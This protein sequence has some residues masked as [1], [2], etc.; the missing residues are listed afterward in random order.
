VATEVSQQRTDEVREAMDQVLDAE[1]EAQAEID[2]AHEKV[3]EILRQARDEVRRIE[4]RARRRQAMIH[5][6][7]DARAEF[8][9]E[10]LRREAG[11]V[12]TESSGAREASLVEAACRRLAAILT[13][14][15]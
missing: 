14:P 2:R 15:S 3:R 13:E 4:E 12:E 5:A 7:C 8:Q 6:A 10:T 11:L 9:I 1:R